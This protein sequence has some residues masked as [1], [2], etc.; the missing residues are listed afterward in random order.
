MICFLDEESLKKGMS[1]FLQSSIKPTQRN[2]I[3]TWNKEMLVGNWVVRA[4]NY[5]WPDPKP[6]EGDKD[7]EV[8]DA[9]QLDN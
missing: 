8:D 7:S 1:K 6:L 5:T 9:G 4:P 3:S 2:E